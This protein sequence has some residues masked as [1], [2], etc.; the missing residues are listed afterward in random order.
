M[1]FFILPLILV[2]QEFQRQDCTSQITGQGDLAQIPRHLRNLCTLISK[3]TEN[4]MQPLLSDSFHIS[5]T[6]WYGPL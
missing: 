5:A 2:H 3:V 6:G 4:I 1:L